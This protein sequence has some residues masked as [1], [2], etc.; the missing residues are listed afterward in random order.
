MRDGPWIDGKATV[1]LLKYL[2]LILSTKLA[3]EPNHHRLTK[4]DKS[5]KTNAVLTSKMLVANRVRVHEKSSTLCL[6][7]VDPISASGTQEYDIGMERTKST[8][9]REIIC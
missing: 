3:K 1:E 5:P 8:I 9:T 4:S 7:L 2:T 6:T